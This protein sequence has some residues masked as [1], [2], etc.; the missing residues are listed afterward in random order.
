MCNSIK[1]I[2]KVSNGE[3]SI[4]KNCNVYH[5]E[6]NNIYFEFTVKQYE[7][8]KNYLLNIEPDYWEDRYA[9]ADLKRKIPIPSLQSNLVLM[10][11]R[12]EI[13]ELKYLFCN[14]Y[15]VFETY[16]KVED[17]DAMVILN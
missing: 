15:S 9:D 14:S 6:Y 2:S 8:F 1:T 10:F 7:Q 12:Q 17:I 4:C 5:L 16:L 3:L 11:N 13:S